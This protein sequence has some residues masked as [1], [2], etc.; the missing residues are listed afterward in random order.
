MP[1]SRILLGVIGRPRGVRG[2]VHVTSYTADPADL[3]SYGVLRD[4][5]GREITLDWR[6]D[7]VAAVT[8]GTAAGRAPVRD[9]E[10]AAA[11]VNTRLYVDRD[12]LPAP[13]DEEYYL[14]DLIGMAVQ[15][16]TGAAVGTVGTV[17][18]YGGG[19]S[20]E[21]VRPGAAPLLLP[22]T[23]ACVPVVDLAAG[24]L[25]VAPPEEILVPAEVSAA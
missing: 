2:L 10:A 9:R 21:I 20:L 17:H 1:E 23:R 14:A 5:A 11:L 25:Q 19:A 18:D 15:D 4:D 3:T 7:G 22:F 13:D 8:L 16:A 24:R 6:A 12:R